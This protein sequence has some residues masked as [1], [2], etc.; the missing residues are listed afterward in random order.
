MGGAS[1]LNPYPVM[2]EGFC[3]SVGVVNSTGERMV[4]DKASL[5]SSIL[6]L[7]FALRLTPHTHACARLANCFSLSI[8]R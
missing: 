8:G 3:E 6:R 7:T 1:Y 5:S 4:V 2:A